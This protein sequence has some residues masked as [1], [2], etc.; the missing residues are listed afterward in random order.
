MEP[1]C[2][3]TVLTFELIISDFVCNGIQLS[4]LLYTYI[5][6]TKRAGLKI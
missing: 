4:G 6:L 5:Y 1:L 2:L 3:A